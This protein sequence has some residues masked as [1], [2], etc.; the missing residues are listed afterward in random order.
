MVFFKPNCAQNSLPGVTPL[1]LRPQR[2]APGRGWSPVHP[3][4]V[5]TWACHFLLPPRGR[6]GPAPA[7]AG[8]SR[9]RGSVSLSAVFGGTVT[10]A[11]APCFRGRS[12]WACLCPRRSGTRG[13]SGLPPAPS[14]SL[15][16]PCGS[17]PPP[18]VCGTADSVFGAYLLAP[19][20]A[21]LSGS[22]SPGARR[23]VGRRR[24]VPCAR[25]P[26]MKTS[27]QTQR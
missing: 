6:D 12:P 21:A 20:F 9:L 15:G 14:G 8:L 24:L 11:R 4:S 2:G 25:L 3:D 16:P 13:V 22:R 10:P 1:D 19:C 18:M 26:V 7:H 27:V 5:R 17:S 23:P